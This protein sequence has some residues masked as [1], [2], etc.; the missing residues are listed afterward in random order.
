[1]AILYLHYPEHVYPEKSIILAKKLKPNEPLKTI[2]GWVESFFGCKHC[3][4]H[5]LNL[6]RDELPMDKNVSAYM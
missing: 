3:K 1:V 2:R 5:F 6:T 4:R